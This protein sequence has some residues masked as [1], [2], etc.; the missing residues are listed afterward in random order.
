MLEETLHH[1][2]LMH[3]A[4]VSAGTWL[5]DTVLPWR[6]AQMIERAATDY[7]ERLRRVNSARMKNDF[8]ERV[9]E[10]RRL[11]EREVRARLEGLAASA[12]HALASAGDAHSTGAIAV[13][14][15]L[16]WLEGVRRRL[17][18]L[19]LAS[20]SPTS[21]GAGSLLV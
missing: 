4:P 18:T 17:G 20:P 7:L 11:L 2:D 19:C 5:R 6:R 15:K 1:T 10:S 9:V 8:E 3:V 12:G 14:E 16:E 21:Q 13:Q